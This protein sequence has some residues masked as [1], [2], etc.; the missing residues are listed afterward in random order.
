MNKKI[1][2]YGITPLM[3]GFLLIS[4]A[5]AVGVV[6]M[7]LGRAE[8]EDAAQCPVDI[9]LKFAQISGLDQICFDSSKR[10]VR[11]TVE[12]GVNIKVEGLI[13]NIIG[14]SDAK[15]Q[16]LTQAKI[17]KVGKFLGKIPYD[18]ATL[19]KPMQIKIT[20][21]VLLYDQE[22]ICQENTLIAENIR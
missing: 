10:E 13:V 18:A 11:F 14:A 3:I 8:V 12:N 7:N 16:D 15:T 19:G 6:V 20:P 22:Q 2:K 17:I 21:K 4:L 9:G 1:N 5:G